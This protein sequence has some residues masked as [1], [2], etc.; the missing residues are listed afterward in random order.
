MQVPSP[1]GADRST[2]SQHHGLRA[3][4]S[5]PSLF[6]VKARRGVHLGPGLDPSNPGPRP[7][8]R[9]HW[10]SLVREAGFIWILRARSWPTWTHCAHVLETF[11][12][13]LFAQGFKSGNRFGEQLTIQ[14][15]R[16]QES[17]APMLHSSSYHMVSRPTERRPEDKRRMTWRLVKPRQTFFNFT[18]ITERERQ[19]DA[20]DTF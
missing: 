13:K 3:F 5:G 6:P 2:Y 17:N 14:M 16:S 19:S 9:S 20:T 11:G 12:P 10:S 8:W 4:G 1:Q 18:R 15:S 7:I